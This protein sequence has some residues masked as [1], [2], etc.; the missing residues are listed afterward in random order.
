M[1]NEDKILPI[2]RKLNI[3]MEN[4]DFVTD[5]SGVKML[6]LIAPRLDFNPKQKM[7]D[8][9][10]R[11]T[12]SE[13]CEKELKWYDSQDRSIYGWVD[14]IT[15]WKQVSDDDGI[16]NSNYGWCIYSEENF[17]QF[18]NA[19]HTLKNHKESRQAIMIYNRPSMHYEYFEN[20][21]SDFTCC[22][23][24]HLLIRDDEL[25]SIV[26]YRSEDIVFGFL[27]DYYWHCVIH[28]RAYNMLLEFY[29]DLKFGKI[30]WFANS[31]HVYERHFS[32]IKEICE[33]N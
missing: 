21:R 30:V 6:E 1:K 10:I 33:K 26:S 16:V 2:I 27:N 29:K 28:E 25:I 20:G 14:D 5:K 15:I 11:K 32:L 19:I 12:N 17:L 8:F 4:K 13:Y 18:D 23:Y 3:K 7:F 31:F 24:Q 9:G 22:M